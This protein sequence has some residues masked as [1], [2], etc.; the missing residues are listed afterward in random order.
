MGIV[1]PLNNPDAFMKFIKQS[2]VSPESFKLI[3]KDVENEIAK[4]KEN[5][6]L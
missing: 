4:M 6:L 3:G 5:G 2:N 1:Q